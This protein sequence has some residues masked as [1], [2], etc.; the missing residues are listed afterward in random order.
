MNVQVVL[1][2][3]YNAVCWRRCTSE[4]QTHRQLQHSI[5]TDSHGWR[6]PWPMIFSSYLWAWSGLFEAN[7]EKWTLGIRDKWG[8][9][10]AKNRLEDLPPGKGHSYIMKQ[11]Q[12]AGYISFCSR[13]L[14]FSLICR[15]WFKV[16]A[17]MQVRKEPKCRL[18]C[19]IP[20]KRRDSSAEDPH[21]Y[22]L[23][24][25]IGWARKG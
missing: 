18:R 4:V 9:E 22:V 15:S 11:L 13:L 23:P 2:C 24:G 7:S 25:L 17:I 3:L 6:R 10:H 8:G 19:R 14:S 5:A 1:L 12:P 20:A 16:M 21:D